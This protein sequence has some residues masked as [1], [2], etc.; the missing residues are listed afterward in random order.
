MNLINKGYDTMVVSLEKRMYVNCIINGID[1]PEL[2]KWRE[3]IKKVE[4]RRKEAKKK[5]E[6]GNFN[7]EDLKNIFEKLCD[8]KKETKKLNELYKADY[9]LT[10]HSQKS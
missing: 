1:R 4:L 3:N 7:I 5:F 2:P 10:S 9:K 8:R 6:H